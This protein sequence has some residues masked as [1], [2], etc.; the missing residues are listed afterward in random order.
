MAGD[1]SDP[2]PLWDR[3][4]EE[5]AEFYIWTDP[6]LDYGTPEGRSGFFESGRRQTAELLAAA[7]PR[8]RRRGRALELGCG[9]GRLLLPHAASFE[10]VV[11]VDVSPRMLSGLRQNARE[12]GVP[13][14]ETYLAGEA[15]DL[16][17]RFDYIWSFLVFQHLPRWREI[18]RYLERI[19][20]AL[21]PDGVAQLQFDTRPRSLPYRLRS[22]LPDFLLPRTQRRGIRRV[23]RSAGSLREAAAAAGLRIL[24]ERGAGSAEHVFLMTPAAPAAGAARA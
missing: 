22:W 1:R 8:L 9:T 2:R 6:A 15:W 16:G 13:N 11:G 4:A 14:V 19:A 20:I 5:N 24:E 12:F 10:R 7:T 18:R 23:R 3:F 17:A 21:E